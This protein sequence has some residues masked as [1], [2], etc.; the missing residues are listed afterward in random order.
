VTEGNTRVRSAHEKK[1]GLR[2]GAD[3]RKGNTESQKGQ[4]EGPPGGR[5]VKAPI[6]WPGKSREKKGGGSS[7]KNARPNG[8][9]RVDIETEENSRCGGKK[10]GRQS[11]VE[12]HES[13]QH[14]PKRMHATSSSRKKERRASGGGKTKRQKTGTSPIFRTGTR[15][16]P[17]GLRRKEGGTP[18]KKKF[19]AAVR[20]KKNLA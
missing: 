11:Q 20:E 14:Q 6:I 16:A 4:A 10:R 12:E 17:M 5:D 19:G 15:K 7:A 18:P 13:R 2:R 9:G 1:R 3:L 8:A